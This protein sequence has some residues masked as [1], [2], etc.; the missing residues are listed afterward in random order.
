MRTFFMITI[1]GMG[2][3]ANL[4][5]KHTQLHKVAEGTHVGFYE[6]KK[7][8]VV[9]D[10]QIRIWLALTYSVEL[11]GTIIKPYKQRRY[12]LH[13]YSH[14]VYQLDGL[15]MLHNQPDSLF[16]VGISIEEQDVQP[17]S[18]TISTDNR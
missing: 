13:F 12:K 11:G 8:I 10:Y 4:Q 14:E 5:I 1:E 7:P 15:G 9:A 18:C 16:K 17:C 3:T 6:P 2:Y